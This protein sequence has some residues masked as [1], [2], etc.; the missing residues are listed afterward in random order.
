MPAIK[1]TVPMGGKEVPCRLLMG[2][3]RR[4]Q[5]ITGKELDNPEDTIDSMRQIHCCAEAEAA[6]RG[7]KLPMSFEQWLD[8]L[9]VDEGAEIIAR[10]NS[11]IADQTPEDG[12]DE[13]EDEADEEKKSSPESSNS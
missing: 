13:T 12:S 11:A 7:E 1:F 5:E 8:S 4:Y 6:R 9:D 3:L 2:A 10:Y